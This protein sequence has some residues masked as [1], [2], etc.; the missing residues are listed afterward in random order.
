MWDGLDVGFEV[1]DGYNIGWRIGGVRWMEYWMEDY[2]CG[3]D[4]ILDG[5]L[6]V[7]DG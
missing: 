4:G 1:W 3:I 7:W 6:D 5:R 2:R